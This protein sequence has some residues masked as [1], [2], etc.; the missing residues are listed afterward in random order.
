M[1]GKDEMICDDKGYYTIFETSLL[2]NVKEHSLNSTLYSLYNEI[3][4]NLK[5][6]TV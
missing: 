4:L 6:N 5:N 3:D 2:T 1:T